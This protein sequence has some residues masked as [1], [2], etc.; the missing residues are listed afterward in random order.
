M[1]A[2]QHPIGGETANAVRVALAG[3]VGI[4]V[5]GH[6]L[7]GAAVATRRRRGSTE[8]AGQGSAARD[9]RRVPSDEDSSDVAETAGPL[10]TRPVG[11]AASHLSDPPARAVGEVGHHVDVAPGAF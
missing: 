9:S 8:P 1:C 3:V 6:L 7:I 11:I 4:V 2:A 5:V 10:P